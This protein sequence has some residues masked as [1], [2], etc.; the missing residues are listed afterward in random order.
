LD[1]DGNLYGTT[2]AGGSGSCEGG[3]GVAYKLTNNGGTWTQTVLH[4]F[5]GGSDGSGPGAPV[6]VDRRGNL[7]GMTPTGG[8]FGVGT[9]YQLHPNQQGNYR[10]RVIHQ[11][12]GGV[13]GLGGSPGRMIFDRQGNLYGASTV[14]GEFGNG[15]VFQLELNGGQWDL[16]PLYSFK[17]DPDAG[18]P[19][20]GLIFDRAGNLYGTTY[21]DGAHEMGAVYQLHQGPNGQWKERVLYS[22]QGGTDGANSI[23]G[24]VWDSQGNLYGTTSEGGAGV[25]VIFKLARDGQGGWTEIVAYTFIGPPDGSLAYNGMIGDGADHFWGTTVHGGEDD[26]GA[27]YQ[28][29]P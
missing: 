10:F 19:Y 13:D 17:G 14:G 15:V 18:F 29:T 2:V 4:A 5:T 9:I 11:F 1:A 16:T 20:G 23:S 21:Y 12:T 27:V 3:C 24:L 6:T 8:A 26:D 7:Y 28:F 22:F 25:G